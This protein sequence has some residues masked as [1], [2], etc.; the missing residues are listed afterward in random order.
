VPPARSNGAKYL[1]RLGPQACCARPSA[2]PHCGLTEIDLWCCASITHPAHFSRLPDCSQRAATPPHR[3]AHREFV[4]P[5]LS[6]PGI[7]TGGT[8]ALWRGYG[9]ASGNRLS[10]RLMSESDQTRPWRHVGVE[11]VLSPTSDIAPCGWDGRKVPCVDG[12][13]LAR[14]IFT[15]RRWSVQ[16]CVRPVSAVHMTAGH[17][18]LRGSGPGQ[19][20]AFDNA[21]AHVGC[22][23]RRIDRLCITCCSPSQPSH[24]AG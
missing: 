20:P 23:D 2:G 6:T 1:R 16:P 4:P 8:I 12:S 22:P 9:V 15:A 21:L 11:S 14:R 10:D 17:N 19:K 3:Q 5:H 13:E 24:Y 7:V 18:A